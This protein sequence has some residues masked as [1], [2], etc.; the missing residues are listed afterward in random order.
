MSLQVQIVE[1]EKVI[2][3][4][5]LIKRKKVFVIVVHYIFIVLGTVQHIKNIFILYFLYFNLG[6]N[7]AE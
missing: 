7:P 6:I 4:R 5:G 3:C 2:G 1:D